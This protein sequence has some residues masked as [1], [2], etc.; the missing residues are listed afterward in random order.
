MHLRV[1]WTHCEGVCVYGWPHASSTQGRGKEKEKI[2]NYGGIDMEAF[3]L[4]LIHHNTIPWLPGLRP[5]RHTHDQDE[6]VFCHPY[7]LTPLGWV[8]GMSIM[9][10]LAFGQ[11]YTL[12]PFGVSWLKEIKR[13]HPFGLSGWTFP[14]VELAFGQPYT[15]IPT[16][17]VYERKSNAMSCPCLLEEAFCHLG[18]LSLGVAFDFSGDQ[19]AC[20]D[21][22][23]SQG[24][25][26]GPR[27][28]SRLVWLFFF[29]QPGAKHFFFF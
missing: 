12:P 17:W 4:K 27:L 22:P 26:E 8:R 3:A 28:N 5:Y 6:L 10:E 9:I 20:V 2:T 25:L 11:P 14:M 1:R 16:R 7:A 21:L 23:P 13:T 24:W 29:F 18:G 15:L 19:P